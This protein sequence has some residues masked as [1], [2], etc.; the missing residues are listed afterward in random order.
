MHTMIDIPGAGDGGFPDTR[1]G[2]VAFR[3]VMTAALAGVGA[4]HQLR[5]LQTRFDSFD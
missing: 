3:G 4:Q 5:R 1:P 2:V